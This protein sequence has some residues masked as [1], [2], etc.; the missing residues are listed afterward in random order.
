[1]SCCS[2]ASGSR[3]EVDSCDIGILELRACPFFSVRFCMPFIPPPQCQSYVL[4]VES[5]GGDT[6]VCGLVRVCSGR[7]I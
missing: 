7:A 5:L 4:S 3:R 6:L 2:N 1:M